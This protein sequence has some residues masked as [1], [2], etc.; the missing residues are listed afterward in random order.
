MARLSRSA[1]WW[2]ALA[3][4][5][6][7]DHLLKTAWPGALTG[8]LSD[9]AGLFVATTLVAAGL[10]P[11]PKVRRALAFASVVVPFCAINLHPYA[12]EALVT[13]LSWVG[14]GWRVTVD[15]TDLMSLLVLPAA[16]R[17]FDPRPNPP[18]AARGLGWRDRA[19][20]ACGA[21][22]CLATS[23]APASFRTSAFIV[24][25]TGEPAE[26]RVRR[27]GGAIDCDAFDDLAVDATPELRGRLARA[28]D[29]SLFTDG[30]LFALEDS[31]VL[32][33]DSS[34]LQ[35]EDLG[36]DDCGVVIVQAEGLPSQII[37]TR[38][39]ETISVGERLSDGAD[40][41]N[42]PRAQ[43]E[44]RGQTGRLALTSHGPPTIPIARD[45]VAEACAELGGAIAA[46]LPVRSLPFEADVLR[47]EALPDGCL[48]IALTWDDNPAPQD[49]VVLCLPGEL[50]PFASTVS[51]AGTRDS[52]IF[53]GPEGRLVIDRFPASVPPPSLEASVETRAVECKG[54]RTLCG[55]YVEPI[56]ITLSTSSGV[57]PLPLGEPRLAADGRTFFLG[58]AGRTLASPFDCEPLG[59]HV[60]LAHLEEYED[61]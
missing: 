49:G 45:I 14:I 41:E 26:I 31:G 23:V 3:V 15:P 38:G 54:A 8:K 18:V 53:T 30:K 51:I 1:I 16:W 39:G 7:N 9:F 61:R 47:V 33:L 6:L 11:E 4:L 40:P 52:L 35:F 20:L 25:F 37:W 58:G 2:L 46:A 56:D 36:E 5:V 59:T 44:L 24:N 42:V 28:L 12:A 50:W 10:G 29:P 34:D 22:A 60:D 17:F 32:P 57:L 55:A 27:Y 19:A 13:A 43:I 48:D 21:A